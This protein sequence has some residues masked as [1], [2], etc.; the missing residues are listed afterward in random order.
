MYIRTPYYQSTQLSQLTGKD[1]FLKLENTQPSGSFKLRGVSKVCQQAQQQNKKKL[2][3]SSGGN[4]GIAVA[5]C[6]QQL[7]MPVEV[8]VP[9]TTTEEAV[10]VLQRL[11]AKV[12]IHGESWAEANALALDQCD[13]QAAY[14]HPFDDESLWHGHA[15]LIDEIVESNEVKPDAIITAVGGGGLFSGLVKGLERN[16]WSD[17]S[18]IAVE[19]EGAA[20]LGK[21]YECNEHIELEKIETIAT[22]LGAKKVCNFAFEARNFMNI[23]P[24]QV[25]DSDAVT[26]CQKFLDDHKML[27]EPAC[28]AALSL[29]YAPKYLANLASFKAIAVVV[30]GGTTFSLQRLLSAVY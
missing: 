3:S 16:N 12:F 27:V 19:T 23:M 1:I 25:T 29:L 11:G 6:G 28:G 26:A 7:G 20:S 2:V 10:A 30:C 15:S 13:A 14:I 21:S 4:A 22:S 18:I 17:V 9:L 24:I 8:Y 5:Y